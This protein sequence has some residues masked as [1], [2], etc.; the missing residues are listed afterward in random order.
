[1]TAEPA[2]SDRG[3]PAERPLVGV[4]VVV[5]KDAQVLL[6]RRGQAPRRGQWSLPG[7][8]Q[9]LGETVRE[10]AVR[11]VREEAGIEISVGPLLDVIDA[12]VRNGDGGIDFHYTLIDFE[13]DWVAGES[14]AGD[15]ADGLVWIDPAEI[16]DFVAWGETVRIVKMSADRR[17][18][19]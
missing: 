17:R 6:I 10:T 13:A 12:V 9:E 11:E 16:G 19:R 7:G 3:K 14:Q 2:D 15:D 5:W 8:K 1:M 4:G 18:A